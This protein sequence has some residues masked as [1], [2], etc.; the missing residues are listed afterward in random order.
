MAASAIWIRPRR[1]LDDADGVQ[2]D[3]VMLGRAAYHEP[4]LLGQVDRRIFGMDVADV[5]PFA[6]IER[7]RPYMTGRLARGASWRAWR[8]TCWV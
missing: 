2:L 3:G 7:Y 5:D 4:A 6:A 1:I 8:G